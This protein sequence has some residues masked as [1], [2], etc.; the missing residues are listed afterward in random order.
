ADIQVGPHAPGAGAAGPRVGGFGWLSD[1][2]R[3][4][5]IP[6]DLYCA[7]AQ[8]DFVT[9][10]AGDR[11]S[12][13]LNSSH[14][15]ISYAVFCLKKKRQGTRHPPGRRYRI[16]TN[17]SRTELIS[18]RA[19]ENCTSGGCARRS[20]RTSKCCLDTSHQAAARP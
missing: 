11:K 10:F 15:K 5:C 4:V 2:T 3:T 1:R 9:R 19:G 12:T 18:Y 16:G 13:R 7:T 20:R 17:C 6:D 14:V 8:D